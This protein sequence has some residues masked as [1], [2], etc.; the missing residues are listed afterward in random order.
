METVLI[1]VFAFVISLLFVYFVYAV[2]HIST[3]HQ[4][5]ELDE[6]LEDYIDHG[7]ELMIE[8][9]MVLE[10]RFSLGANADRIY[11][12]LTKLKYPTDEHRKLVTYCIDVLGKVLGRNITEKDLNEAIVYRI[13]RYPDIYN[14][15]FC[16]KLIAEVVKDKDGNYTHKNKFF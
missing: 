14:L 15:F 13:S 16:G 7:K 2:M 1:I 11:Y 9:L 5:E 4:H 12:Y 8:N 3:D 6:A 10:K